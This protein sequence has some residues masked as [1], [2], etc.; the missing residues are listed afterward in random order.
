MDDRAEL[1]GVV[2]ATI[3]ESEAVM[4]VSGA[5]YAAWRL[6]FAPHRSGHWHWLLNCGGSEPLIVLVHPLRRGQVPF[7]I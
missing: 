3:Q 1:N 7:A 2:R 5:S 6:N 4:Q